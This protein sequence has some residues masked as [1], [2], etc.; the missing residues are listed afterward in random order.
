MKKITYVL[1]LII[2]LILISSCTTSKNADI[3]TT[4][5]PQYDFAR[6]IVGNKMSVSLLIP[7]GVEVHSYEATSKDMVAI[8]NAK[9]FIYTSSSIDQW[10][11]EP[12]T[13]GGK[14][15]VVMDLSARYTLED[16]D[17][18][19]PLS[20]TDDHDD[21]DHDD[22]IHY[23][24]DPL[25][26]IQLIDAILEEIVLLDPENEDFYR[27]NAHAYQELIHTLHE[28][29]DAFIQNGLIDSEIYFAGHNAMGLF[30]TRYHLHIE[31]LFESFKPDADLTSS[32]L[33]TFTS[34]VMEE[35]VHIL[36]IEE[37]MVPKAALQI[38][39]ELES[40]GYSLELIE[41]HGYHNITKTEMEEGVRYV[42]LF[43]RNI[44]RITLALTK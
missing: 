8:K 12:S 27:S 40:N 26:A 21:H 43:E 31:S 30:G 13:I 16:H 23:W 28:S 42:D 18:I 33:I 32:E 1:F 2:S 29:F 35:N 7:P 39:Q 34:I 20:N 17:H 24:V 6:Q 38:K 22:E 25:I 44:A 19:H 5:F 36:F 9:L 14:D 10:I 15:T 37:L 4:M 11:K 41:L 3:V